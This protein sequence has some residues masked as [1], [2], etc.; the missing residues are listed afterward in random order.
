VY[1]TNTELDI[2]DSKFFQEQLT[3]FDMYLLFDFKCDS[4]VINK[5]SF[6]NSPNI[7]DMF[8]NEWA[9][10]KQKIEFNYSNYVKV[11]DNKGWFDNCNSYY[12]TSKNNSYGK[13][14]IIYYTMNNV[15]D[16][17]KKPLCNLL[18]IKTDNPITITHSSYNFYY[19][20]GSENKIHK[21]S[22]EDKNKYF[23]SND[24]DVNFDGITSYDDTTQD[25][26]TN[27]SGNKGFYIP[28][29]SSGYFEVELQILQDGNYRVYCFHKSFSF[30][31]ESYYDRTI[32]VKE[33][34][35]DSIA[36]FK[37]MMF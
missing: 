37:R 32:T 36:N 17:L 12:L 16:E 4:E 3:N 35:F 22:Y 20:V 21:Y 26:V 25:V 15:Y 18:S 23:V 9:I 30:S 28:T 27:L 14:S 24:F 13:Q 7:T 34:L 19:S 33:I 29:R 10:Q 11:E 5:T 31:S 1:Q 8:V 6:C 2:G